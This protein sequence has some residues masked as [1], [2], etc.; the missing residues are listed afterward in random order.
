M[1]DHAVV[2]APLNDQE[3]F[4]DDTPT[5]FHSSSGEPILVNDIVRARD[6][7]GVPGVVRGTACAGEILYLVQWSAGGEGWYV[8]S[9]LKRVGP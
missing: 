8:R 4:L 6:R 7:L 1:K 2:L 3:F 5:G 9:Q